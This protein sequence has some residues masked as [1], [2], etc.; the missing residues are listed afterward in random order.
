MDGASRIGLRLASSWALAMVVIA[1][2]VCPAQ[3]RPPAGVGRR[4]V[5]KPGPAPLP[6]LPALPTQDDVS[7]YAKTDVPH[8]TV[9][10]ATYTNH[11]GQQKRMH[12]YLPP[13]YEKDP[14]AT[15]PVLYLNHGGGEDD[16]HWTHTAPGG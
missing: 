4:P 11:A 16:S 6:I 7:F 5:P 3:D 12:V 1:A 15:Y 10:Q 8:G 14:A 9:E 2:S 13:G